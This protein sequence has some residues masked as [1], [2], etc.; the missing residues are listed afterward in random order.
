MGSGM[1]QDATDR[2]CLKPTKDTRCSRI[3]A[4]DGPDHWQPQMPADFM[5]SE[6]IAVSRRNLDLVFP[7]YPQQ[8]PRGCEMGS[9]AGLMKVEVII[10]HLGRNLTPKLGC[11][12]IRPDEHNPM[13]AG[14]ELQ[15]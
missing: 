1:C 8:E 9:E 3:S 11:L 6:H 13:P 4:M 10:R 14:M 15:S 7:D 5:H 12:V 2:E